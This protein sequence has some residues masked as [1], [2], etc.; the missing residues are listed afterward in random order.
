MR[1]SEL[2]NK[3]IINIVDGKKIG[4]IIDVDIDQNGSLR[5]LISEKYRFFFSMFSSKAETEIKWHQI[6]KIGADVILVNL[7]KLESD[8]K[9][10]K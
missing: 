9:K 1:L 5:S 4:R 7:G 3:D 2:Q 10:R 6:E 8:D